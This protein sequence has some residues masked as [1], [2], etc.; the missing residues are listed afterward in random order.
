M[1]L[2]HMKTLSLRMFVIRLPGTRR[3]CTCPTIPAYIWSRRAPWATSPPPGPWS[4]RTS[5]C[6]GSLHR[7]KD[8]IS[9]SRRRTVGRRTPNTVPHG[10]PIHRGMATTIKEYGE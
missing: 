4:P 5:G 2:D 9:R 6:K 10:N 1:L 8:A 3:R 7:S